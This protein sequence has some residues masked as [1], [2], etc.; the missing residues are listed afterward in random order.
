MNFSKASLST[1]NQIFFGENKINI[2]KKIINKNA[3]NKILIVCS[4]RGKKVIKKLKVFQSILV[5][6]IIWIDN[7]KENICIDYFENLDKNILKNNFNY[8]I[9]FGGG[10]AIDAAKTI[11]HYIIF[12]NFHNKHKKIVKNSRPTLIAIPTTSGT[13]S[14]VTSTATIWNFKKK[15]KLSLSH[16]FLLPR[17]AI[18]DPVLTYTMSR[19][20]TFNSG[21]DA[22]NQCFDSLWNH[23]ANKESKL[24]AIEGIKLAYISLKELE[25]NYN[26]KKARLNL[27]KAS[28][29]SG[30]AIKHTKT[31]ICHAISYPF[32]LYFKIP[33]GLACVLSM[34]EVIR[35]V[36]FNKKFFFSSI[37]LKKI[38]LSE[39]PRLF[40]KLSV[41]KKIKK[42]I[43]YSIDIEK[44]INNIYYS[45]RIKNFSF[46]ITKNQLRTI[47]L[48]SLT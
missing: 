17:Y 6:E 29:I 34:L 16:S 35:F 39:I 32:T 13:G 25:K 27:S 41:K 7:I 14:E 33:H 18:V 24:Y 19:Q 38:V 9:G 43:N 46:P 3:R 8:V 31:S 45:D 2:L 20:Q 21:L 30:L 15:K 22:L 47:V 12:K 23:R 36:I 11:I 48:K 42:Y 1:K 44:I 4:K 5:N 40:L 28:L 37:N 10:S 26:N